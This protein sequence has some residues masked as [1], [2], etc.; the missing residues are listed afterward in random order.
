[1]EDIIWVIQV[2]DIFLLRKVYQWQ[3]NEALETLTLEDQ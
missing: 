1:M 3:K 2:Q